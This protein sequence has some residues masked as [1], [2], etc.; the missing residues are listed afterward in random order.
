M[1]TTSD[2][3]LELQGALTMLR[4]IFT[5]E[6]KVRIMDSRGSEKQACGKAEE[7]QG[8]GGYQRPCGTIY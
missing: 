3:S 6:K 1:R 2:L 5:E 8:Y 7:D 4:V